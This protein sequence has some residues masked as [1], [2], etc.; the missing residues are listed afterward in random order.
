M[1][2]LDSIAGKIKNVLISDKLPTGDDIP[3][4]ATLKAVSDR[5]TL[6]SILPY[7]RYDEQ[8]QIYYNT[9]TYGFMIYCAPSTGLVSEN[10]AV[11][12]G[13]FKSIHPTGTHIQVSIISDSNIEYILDNW[14]EARGHSEEAVKDN[15]QAD[16]ERQKQVKDNDAMFKLLASNRVAH[17]KDGK[18]N[19]KIQSQPYILRNYH[20]IITYSRPYDK[21]FDPTNIE[22]FA[23]EIERMQ[24]TKGAMI[25]TLATAKIPAKNFHPN[26]FINIMNGIF[27]PKLGEQ[28][29]LHYDEENFLNEQLVSA[30]TVFL[31]SAAGATI[32]H[33]E[34]KFSMLPFH[35][36]Q[37]P[38]VWSAARNGELIGAFYNNIL[39][40]GCP[41]I[42][43]LNVLIPD[44]TSSKSSAITHST[45]AT[46]MA[47]S[48]IAKYL[49]QWAER[50]VDW[51]FTVDNIE[52]G[53]KLLESCYQIILLTKQGTEQAVEESLKSLYS[54]IG[55]QITRSRYTAL[56]AFLNALPMGASK[57]ILQGMR[58]FKYYKRTL[59]WTCTNIAPFVAEWKG[60]SN[61]M[62][63][64]SGRRGQIAYF[65]PFENDK[66]NYNIACCA[67]SGSG[68]SFVT[69]DWVFNCLGSGGR[70]FI[71]D[72]GHSYRNLCR[73]L[74][75]TYIDFGDYT[76]TLCV[77]PFSNIR[78][79]FIEVNG[80]PTATTHFEE[81]LPMIKL[82]IMQA[83]TGNE[84]LNKKEEAFIE[85]A[86][87]QAWEE[88]KNE[89]CFD[90]V[91]Q[92]L[93]VD[94]LEESHRDS[95]TGID[96]AAALTSYSKQG[97]YG[98]YVNGKNNV[99]LT[100]PFVVMDLDALNKTPDLQSVALL[101][102]MMQITQ[103]MYLSG[104]KAQRKL[105]IIDEAWRLLKASSTAGALH[106]AKNIEE[107]YR[108]ARKHGG[109]FMTIT[110]RISDYFESET[111]KSALMNSDFTIY[112]RQKPEELTSAIEKSYIDNADGKIDIL[113]SLE[114][115]QGQ[116]SE[117]AVSS[118]DGM[119]VF[120]LI[121]DKVT[122]KIYST[123]PKEVEFLKREQAK[124]VP[125]MEAIQLLIN[126]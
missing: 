83:A 108:V 114:T 102:L 28:P 66:G 19:T 109:S 103:I 74:N 21:T 121:T 34:E 68:K 5:Y 75:G 122:E 25:S 89:A 125:L 64:F 18:W 15:L 13:I 81:Q 36:R 87:V 33:G 106:A 16:A 100:N 47:D 40:V 110:Q 98:K 65:D 94:D 107:G 84:P 9:D 17:L 70:A 78:D 119:A 38:K 39:R 71:I 88:K 101:M 32:V 93:K 22:A 23:P 11:L 54:S 24:R 14:K 69:Q 30:E 53:E 117:L 113:R 86:I 120:R 50:K 104:N 62:M 55:W 90:D 77:N 8:S 3:T 20:L 10:I 105:C 92:N 124:G 96:L 99:D 29:P 42:V 61:P 26:H 44:Q 59:S 60:H 112:L 79:E 27:N 73:L 49:P 97:M 41:F 63:I 46:Q 115:I 35:V 12:N 6:S 85:R 1:N 37:F 123:S 67:T 31:P 7:E 111:T 52:N 95:G 56:H 2:I 72:C 82:L 116:Y 57:D 76:K 45:R 48:P 51:Q 80:Q 126:Q 43:T 4:I 58:T 91:I 118:P